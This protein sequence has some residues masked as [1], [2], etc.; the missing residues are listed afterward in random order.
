M[1]LVHVPLPPEAPSAASD[2]DRLLAA[3]PER[4][5]QGTAIDH[6]SLAHDPTGQLVLGFF[7]AAPNLRAAEE[8][9][10]LVLLNSGLFGESLDSLNIRVGPGLVAEFLEKLL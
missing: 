2:L 1:Y 4:L 5:P 6:L 7:V 3:V 10:R 8:A 9:A